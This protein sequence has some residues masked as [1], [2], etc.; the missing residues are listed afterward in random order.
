MD[1]PKFK[2]GLGDNSITYPLTKSQ[3]G[4]LK[5]CRAVNPMVGKDYGLKVPID[6]DIKQQADELL[7]I[8][9]EVDAGIFPQWAFEKYYPFKAE[10]GQYEFPEEILSIEG[11]STADPVALGLSVHMD[12]PT[13]IH[14]TIVKWLTNPMYGQKV[15]VKDWTPNHVNFLETIPYVEESISDAVKVGLIKAFRAKWALGLQRPETYIG[16]NMTLYPE[17]CPCH[18]EIPQGHVSASVSGAYD[19]IKQFPTLSHYQTK[20]ILDV[21]YSWG[22]FRVLAGVHWQDT[23]VA[24][25]IINGFKPFIRR[26]IIRRFT[27]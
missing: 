21:A 19:I 4:R 1:Y 20:K 26:D 27:K 2:K 7:K 8:R 18:G 5:P 12:S 13:D 16:R 17:G 6:F 22:F 23:V 3:L 10:W 25:M 14:R 9:A 11:L 24:G 15:N